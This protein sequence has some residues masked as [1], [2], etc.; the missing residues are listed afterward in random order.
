M[1]TFEMSASQDV[2]KKNCELVTELKQNSAFMYC[3]SDVHNVQLLV[4]LKPA[5]NKER[6]PGLNG[7]YKNK[8]VQQLINEV[9]FK[10]KN[11]EGVKWVKFYKPFPLVGYAL[12]L[13]AVCTTSST[14]PAY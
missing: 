3:V 12:A 11:S 1:F 10:N 7:I 2:V 14:F 5:S 13:T 8:G 6:Y 4:Y 9:L